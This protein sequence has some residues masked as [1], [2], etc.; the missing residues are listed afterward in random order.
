MCFVAGQPSLTFHPL[1][2]ARQKRAGYPT[3]GLTRPLGLEE[4]ETEGRE[5]ARLVAYAPKREFAPLCQVHFHPDSCKP[6]FLTT[7]VLDSPH[8]AAKAHSAKLEIFPQVACGVGR[9]PGS[10]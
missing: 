5:F 8:A 4:E 9:F 10:A 1:T 2:K 3:G 7:A 6:A